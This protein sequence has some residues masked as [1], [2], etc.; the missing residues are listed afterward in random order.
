MSD[1]VQGFYTFVEQSIQQSVDKGCLVQVACPQ[2]GAVTARCINE[3]CDSMGFF[4]LN[5]YN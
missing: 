3:G 2:L 1:V 4:Y 5:V